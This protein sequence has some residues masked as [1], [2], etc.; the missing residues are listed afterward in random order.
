[1]VQHGQEFADVASA[2]FA[3]LDEIDAGGKN[4]ALPGQ[5]DGF[6]IRLSQFHEARRQR[7]AEFDVECIG[8]AMLESQHSDAA[9]GF[10][11]DHAAA[12]R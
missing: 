3:Q 6:C 8:V 9:G 7:L 1:L 4:L 12:L 11:I 10:D 2:A 5:N